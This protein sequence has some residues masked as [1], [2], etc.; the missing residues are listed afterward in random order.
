MN[1]LYNRNAF[2]KNQPLFSE[3]Q[4]FFS[5]KSALSF[6]NHPYNVNGMSAH[7]R[8]T[9]WDSE[10]L[11][12]LQETA[13]NSRLNFVPTQNLS[14]RGRSFVPGGKEFVLT[15][16]SEYRGSFLS[17]VPWEKNSKARKGEYRDRPYE[18]GNTGKDSRPAAAEARPRSCRPTITWKPA[19]R[20]HDQS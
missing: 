6:E 11:A 10:W 2:S 19:K 5:K 3:N 1:R 14:L 20:D 18:K 8:A 17:S 12:S 7:T 13:R 4:P 16:K 9:D 15:R